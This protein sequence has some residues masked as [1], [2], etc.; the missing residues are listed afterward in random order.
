MTQD[1]KLSI[2]S[3]SRA[4]TAGLTQIEVLVA[5]LILG[6]ATPFL[7]TGILHGLAQLLTVRDGQFK[8]L[9]VMPPHF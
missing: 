8:L 4:T 2:G 7:L 9:A 5:M 3:S 1:S 6:L